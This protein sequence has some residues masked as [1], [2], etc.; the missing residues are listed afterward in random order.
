MEDLDTGSFKVLEF[1]GDEYGDVRESFASFLNMCG[2]P[3]K[4]TT[5]G[6]NF[7]VEQFASEFNH[8]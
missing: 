7:L 3:E 8:L 2:Y 5:S 1:K 4:A 6:K